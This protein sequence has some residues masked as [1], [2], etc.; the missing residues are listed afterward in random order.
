[1]R[2]LVVWAF[3]GGS[4][5]KGLGVQDGAEVAGLWDNDLGLLVL[6]GANGQIGVLGQDFLSVEV[7]EGSGGILA[8][9][10]LQDSFTTGVGHDEVCQV[11]DDAVDDAP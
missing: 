6:D 2:L 8:S 7:V 9:N 4:Q 5:P 11:I 1:M 3:E 10:L